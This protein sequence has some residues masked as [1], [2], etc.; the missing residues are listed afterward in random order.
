[1]SGSVR[2][3]GIGSPHGDDQVGW[4]LVALLSGQPGLGAQLVSVA[5]AAA[6]LD[7]L[8]G[9][10]RLILVDACVT[11]LA[12][13]S[14]TR[15]EWPDARISCQHSRTTHDLSVADALHLASRLGR[16]PARVAI[17]GVEIDSWQPAAEMS[18]VVSHVLPELARRIIDEVR[19]GG[20]EPAIAC[21]ED[22]EAIP[23]PAGDLR[24]NSV[25]RS[26][27]RPQRVAGSGD[28]P[29]RGGEAAIACREDLML[30]NRNTEQVDR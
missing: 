10:C 21:R 23:K 28:R 8:D 4:R 12:P 20:G 15:L 1:M 3:V 11:G 13:G 5:G 7:H 24:S 30:N 14:I 6:L 17:Y 22:L 29:Q 18:Q 16:L 25:A 2:I 19:S 27:D 26:G 9:C